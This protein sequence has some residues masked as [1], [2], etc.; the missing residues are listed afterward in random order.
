MSGA[1]SRRPYGRQQPGYIYY[2]LCGDT[3]MAE[4]Y[5]RKAMETD[6][7]RAAHNLSELARWLE[8]QQNEN[9]A[10]R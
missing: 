2:W 3:A 1:G 10:S 8:E 7:V 4:Q 9:E 6:P 5:F